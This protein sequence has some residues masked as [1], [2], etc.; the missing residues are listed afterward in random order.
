MAR[1]IVGLGNIGKEY[2]GTNHN[3]GFMVLDKVAKKFNVQ[4][5]KNICSRYILNVSI[6]HFKFNI[7]NC[8]YHRNQQEQIDEVAWH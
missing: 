1:L 5:K 8:R 6:I 4:I 3:M 2:D 7:T